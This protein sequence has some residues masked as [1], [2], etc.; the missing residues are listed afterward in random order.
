MRDSLVVQCL[1]DSA[2]ERVVRLHEWQF[3][4]GLHM[5]HLDVL[6]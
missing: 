6:S 2:G 5:S 3:V 4:M 1:F